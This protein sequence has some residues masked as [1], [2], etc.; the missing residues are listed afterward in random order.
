MDYKKYAEELEL[1]IMDKLL[2]MYLVGCRSSGVR[3]EQ[4]EILKKLL[5]TRRKSRSQVC[6]L[7]MSSV[8]VDY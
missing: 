6:A 7:L 2:P 8:D 5:E 3:S 4:N 1:L